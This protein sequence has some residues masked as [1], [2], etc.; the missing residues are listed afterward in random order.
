M[1]NGIFHP[2]NLLTGMSSISLAAL[3]PPIST[4][5]KPQARTTEETSS[6]ALLES[7]AINTCKLVKW[8]LQVPRNDYNVEMTLAMLSTTC[9]GT[10]IHGQGASEL[11]SASYGVCSESASREAFQRRQWQWSNALWSKR[12]RASAMSLTKARSG[13]GRIVLISL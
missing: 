5:V 8:E 11:L 12:A 2:S 6:L 1:R 4:G 7:P 3:S 13:S 9:W 10:L